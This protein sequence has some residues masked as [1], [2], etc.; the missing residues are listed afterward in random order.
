MLKPKVSIIVPVYKTEKYL[1]RCVDSL[2]NQSLKEIEIILIDD[3]SPD[4]SPKLCDDLAAEDF[5]I[6]VVHKTNEG[7]GMARN[8]GIDEASGEYIGFVDSDDYVKKDMFESLYKAAEKHNASLVLSGLSFVGGNMFCEDGKVEEKTFFE[9]ET[10]FDKEEDIKGLMLGI[11]GA[12]PY[13]PQDSRYGASVCKNIFKLDDIRK[14]NVRF[15]SERKILSEDTLFM[16]DY[17]NCIKKAVGIPGAY[18]CYCRN[19][20]SLSKIYNPKR[21]E[22]SMIFLEEVEER[23]KNKM[24]EVEYK[25]YLD[26]LTQAF[27]RVL[28]S[29]EI[30]YA[31]TNNVKY[32]VLRERL[33]SICEG[34]KIEIVLKSYPWHRLPLKQAVFAFA[35][36]YRLYLLLKI[37]VALRDK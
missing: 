25:I 1:K 30:M 34:T 33:K 19:D 2:K 10:L 8:S 14:N 5:R 27:G 31:K 32:T 28:C 15:L 21:F 12:L 6:K 22:K 17:V 23:L 13:E 16:L 26:R 37:L 3:G 20:E 9:K 36:K 4:N 24:A 35:M 7:L 18:Y 11:A 29:Q